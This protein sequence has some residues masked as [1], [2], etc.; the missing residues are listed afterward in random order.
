M[1]PLAKGDVLRRDEHDRIADTSALIGADSEKKLLA[2]AIET[3]EDPVI[4]KEREEA[5]RGRQQ[6]E[7][8]LTLVEKI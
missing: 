5:E 2:D 8:D 6:R 4:K 3:P 7:A 1:V